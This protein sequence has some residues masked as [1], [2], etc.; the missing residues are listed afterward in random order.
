MNEY[1]FDIDAY[2]QRIN[3][4]GEKTPTVDTLKS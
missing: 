2:L 1:D 4:E 3:Y